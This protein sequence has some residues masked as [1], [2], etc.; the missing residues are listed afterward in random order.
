[1][2]SNV[3]AIEVDN[4]EELND[5]RRRKANSQPKVDGWY[6]KY[7]LLI[8]MLIYVINFIDRQI[9]S[10]LAEDIKADFGLSDGDL[11]FLYGAAFAVFYAV[12]GIPLA[13]LADSWQRTRL[14]SIGVGFW[15]L[16]TTLSG[17]ARG[18]TTLAIYRFGVGA[19]EASATPAAYSLLYDYFSPKIRTTVVAIYGSGLYVGMGLGLFIGG[20]ILDTWNTAYPSASLA[21]F[22]LK[23]W[24]VAFMAV[25]LP[26]LL[27]SVWMATLREPSR[28]LA[29]GLL[30]VDKHENPL[31]L[32]KKEL[33][34]MVPLVNLWVFRQAGTGVKPIFLNISVGIFILL[35]SLL[36]V[37]LTGEVLQWSAL[38]VGLYCV[39]SWIQLLVTRDPVCFELIFKTK[40]ILNL[41]LAASFS[42]FSSV[43]II[44]W[45]IPYFQRFYG[46]KAADVGLVIGLSMSIA[47]LLGMIIGGVLADW[48]RGYNQ[49]AKLCICLGSWLMSL[50]AASLMLLV[51]TLSV[52]YF[53]GFVF[54]LVGP[55]AQAPVLSTI[56]DLMI[57]RIRAVA[58]AVNIMI[59]TFIGFA[60]G[61]YAVGLL[62]DS[63]VAI[64]VGSGEALRK[65]LLIGLT[66][67][68]AA[69]LLLL[70]AIKYF[71]VDENS[72]LL[73]ARKSGEKI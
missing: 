13:R 35:A 72:R 22:G 40:T 46:V 62:S 52:A 65:S 49:H 6:A 38:A 68:V 47:G 26:G 31:K 18:F 23:G 41:N 8:L 51:E 5:F 71:V 1:M 58:M 73:R 9:I 57:P 61:P 27:L 70:V 2:N 64:G 69:I 16:M 30:A 4:A 66:M 67:Q 11:G 53:F 28:G 56:S 25:G 45:C 60:L 39:F 20:S 3:E 54:F 29:D 59:T 50:M 17:T 12:F 21:P 44:F 15:S 32:L 34:P 7:A 33:L 10:I 36:L 55:M 24:Q 43:A 42:V 63:F 19:G 48:L 37:D 14:I